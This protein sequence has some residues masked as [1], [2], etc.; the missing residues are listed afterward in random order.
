M[1]RNSWVRLIGFDA[2]LNNSTGYFNFVDI[3]FGIKCSL[4][5]FKLDQPNRIEPRVMN[6]LIA[7]QALSG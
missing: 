6:L 3:K 1:I 4:C 2:V 7:F 5:N